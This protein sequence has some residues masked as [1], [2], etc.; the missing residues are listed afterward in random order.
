[1][2]KRKSDALLVK[3]FYEESRDT[4]CPD[5][6]K[7][8]NKEEVKFLIRM[9]FSEMHELACTV[10]D[11]SSEAEELMNEC[12]DNMDYHKM[13]SDKEYFTRT[14]KIAA[15]VDALVDSW[16]YSLDTMA[17]HG[18]DASK[19]FDIVHEANMNKRDPET[20]KFIKRDSDGK[21]IKPTGWKAPDVEGE[22][23]RQIDHGT[24]E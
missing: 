23:Q 2:T 10:S 9:I 3:E 12:F 13:N 4:K 18:V 5:K 14:K 8:M 1:M 6:P 15:Q 20:K 11:S 24:W 22:I 21:V 16:Y 7:E 19:I 17:K